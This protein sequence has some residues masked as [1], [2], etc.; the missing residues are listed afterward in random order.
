MHTGMWK[1]LGVF[2]YNGASVIQTLHLPDEFCWKH[3]FK[4]F[5]TINPDFHDPDA[6]GYFF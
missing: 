1:L 6:D 5:C 4:L 3:I 2:K